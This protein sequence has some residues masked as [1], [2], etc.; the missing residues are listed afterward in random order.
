MNR[1]GSAPPGGAVYELTVVGAMGDAFRAAVTPHDV[2][3][4]EVCTVLRTAGT[5]ASD[6]VDL[7]LLL[8]Q[9]GIA[10][11]GVYGIDS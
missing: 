6:M 5:S 2:V 3:R 4:S 11:E 8:E 7:V 10:V 1:P 9:K